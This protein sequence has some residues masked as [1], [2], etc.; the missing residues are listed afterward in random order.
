MNSEE[1]ILRAETKE[2]YGNV[3]IVND[4]AYEQKNESELIGRLRK[5]RKFIPELSIVAETNGSVRGHIFF[6]PFYIHSDFKNY[7][8]LSLTTMAVDPD[9]HNKGIGSSLVKYGLEQCRKFDFD[10]VIVLGH[11]DFY[12]RFGFEQAK[13]W[14]IRLPFAAPEEAFMALELVTGALSRIWG[15]VEYPDEYFVSC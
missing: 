8:T 3:A 12:P 1:V 11:P 14:S 9:F 7:E 6:F 10:S 4:R 13:K 5:N 2:D 15:E